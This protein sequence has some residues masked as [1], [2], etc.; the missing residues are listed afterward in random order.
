MKLETGVLLP[1]LPCCSALRLT[2][3]SYSVHA[4]RTIRTFFSC[5][6][7]VPRFSKL[8]T[9]G[10]LS[11]HRHFFGKG[12]WML[13]KNFEF[14]V[15]IAIYEILPSL[16]YEFLASVKYCSIWL[17][18]QTPARELALLWAYFSTLPT[19]PLQILGL[20]EHL[21][22]EPLE[23]HHLKLF[24]YWISKGTFSLGV[25]SWNVIIYKL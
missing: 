8:I 11:V 23:L 3:N 19:D 21:N 7:P 1:L 12:A 22:L 17:W 25:T 4:E 10:L 2:H 15:N 24:G 14:M 16:N 9:C 5:S 6:I 20:S 13:F 18:A